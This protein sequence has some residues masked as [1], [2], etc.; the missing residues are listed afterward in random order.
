MRNMSFMMF[1]MYLFTSICNKTE[2][3]CKLNGIYFNVFFLNVM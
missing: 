3:K 2:N 1:K